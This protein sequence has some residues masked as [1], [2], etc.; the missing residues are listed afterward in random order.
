MCSVNKPN[1]GSQLRRDCGKQSTTASKNGTSTGSRKRKAFPASDEELLIDENKRAKVRA[2]QTSA[3][4]DD[5]RE[6][7]FKEVEDLNA[8]VTEENAALTQRISELQNDKAVAECEKEK[9]MVYGKS[10]KG[11]AQEWEAYG[12]SQEVEVARLNGKDTRAQLDID[13][14]GKRYDELEATKTVLSNRNVVLEELVEEY[15][16]DLAESKLRQARISRAR[17][18]RLTKVDTRLAQAEG[19]Y[20]R[21][22]TPVSDDDV[23]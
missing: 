10:W 18:E 19:Y 13:A 8:S 3:E 5:F 16:K 23:Y 7:K 11:K 2:E 12:L 21:A 1:T 17:G 15:R 6:K 14:L 4:L 20:R 22:V 9:W